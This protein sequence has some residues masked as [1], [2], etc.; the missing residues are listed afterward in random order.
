ML[1][2]F[3]A[4]KRHSARARVSRIS[5]LV[6]LSGSCSVRCRAPT[7]PAALSVQ[8]Q[9]RAAL[10]A[11]PPLCE[12]NAELQRNW[13]CRFD[14]VRVGTGALAVKRHRNFLYTLAKQGKFVIELI[15]GFHP[16]WDGSSVP[17]KPEVP[18]F[19]AIF[20]SPLRDSMHILNGAS[21]QQPSRLSH[22]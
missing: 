3:G 10:S 6:L 20:E 21:P 17:G 16:A 11:S 9:P 15:P 2:S 5:L 7:L 14:E 4:F 13:V 8:G 22:L 18:N 19:T 12:S 1:C